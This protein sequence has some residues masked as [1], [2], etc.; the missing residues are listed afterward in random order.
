MLKWRIAIY[1]TCLMAFFYSVWWRRVSG[2]FSWMRQIIERPWRHIPGR[3]C[4]QLA[5]GLV[6]KILNSNEFTIKF[7]CH[8][9]VTS[10]PTDTVCMLFGER[11]LRSYTYTAFYTILPILKG[12][13]WNCF[14]SCKDFLLYLITCY[15]TEEGIVGVGVGGS[16]LSLYHKLTKIV[17]RWFRFAQL[18][19]GKKSRP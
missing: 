18:A 10:S 19:K 12:Q 7:F 11:D 9:S 17:C 2:L 6:A 13:Y 15:V 8:S 5:R 14:D 4:P 1:C 3:S 16:V